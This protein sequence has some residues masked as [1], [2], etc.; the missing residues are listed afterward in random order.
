MI[1]NKLRILISFLLIFNLSSSCLSHIF[2]KTGEVVGYPLDRIESKKP[3]LKR[4]CPFDDPAIDESKDSPFGYRYG[5]IGALIGL[6]ADLGL[7]LYIIST[8]GAAIL[9][10]VIYFFTTPFSWGEVD[11]KLSNSYRAELTK[12]RQYT[13]DGWLFNPSSECENVSD[14]FVYRKYKTYNEQQVSC[15][16]FK[17]LEKT[18]FY[19]FLITKSGFRE[20]DKVKLQKLLGDPIMISTRIENENKCYA[21]F[22]IEF[23]GGQE[24]LKK[25]ISGL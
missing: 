14:F 18:K 12:S 3:S 17:K 1:P 23:L 25:K 22:Y 11:T 20:S 8:G 15:V 2:S 24:A 5:I 6:I 21:E 7:G 19:D 4:I 16:E 13:Y 9:G 10:G